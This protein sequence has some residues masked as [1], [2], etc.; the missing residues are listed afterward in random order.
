MH[1]ESRYGIGVLGLFLGIAT[2]ALMGNASAPT[3]TPA[4]AVTHTPKP[5]AALPTVQVEGAWIRWLPA[6]L[7]A[8]GY[9]T[10]NNIGDKPVTLL[11]ASSPGFGE[12]SLHRNR[13]QSGTL[14]MVPVEKIT[15]DPHSSVKFAA[16]G[17]HMMLRQP[18]QSIKP[19]DHVPITLRFADGS[20]LTVEFEVRKPDSS[21][22]AS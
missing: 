9:A 17:Y 7:P 16:A 13:S 2:T 18:T 6:N 21:R 8:A 19:G 15:I 11:A 14:E 1:F 4:P 20:A 12:I 5:A 22:E 3:P 10:I